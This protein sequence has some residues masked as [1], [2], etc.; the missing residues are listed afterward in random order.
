VQ[1]ETLA[2]RKKRAQM[3]ITCA[4]LLRMALG[5]LC[6]FVVSAVLDGEKD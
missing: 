5:C 4:P 2:I 1:I 6:W 3:R